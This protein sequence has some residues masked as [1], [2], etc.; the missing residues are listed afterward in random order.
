MNRVVIGVGSNIEPQKHIAAARER[1]A[2]DHR[3]LAESRFVETRPIGGPAQPNF[4]NGALL[5][6]TTMSREALKIWLETVEADLGRVR[7]ANRYDPRTIDLDIVVWN[8][9][10]V[11][12]DVY[13][14]RFL[15]EA[16]LEVWPDPAIE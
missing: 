15:R 6:E 3:L 11:D 8:G 4:S 9:E 12:P 16:V 2:R 5:I 7:G 10:I 14:R 1:I 13:E